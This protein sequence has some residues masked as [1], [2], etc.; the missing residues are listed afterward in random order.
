MGKINFSFFFQ[1]ESFFPWQMFGGCPV[2]APAYVYICQI[3]SDLAE[4]PAE[5]ILLKGRPTLRE[6]QK[7]NDFLRI[8][9]ER[10]QYCREIIDYQAKKSLSPGANRRQ[11]VFDFLANNNDFIDFFKK[12]IRY[13]YQQNY[14]TLPKEAFESE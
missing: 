3:M 14:I 2:S 13:K 11:E 6:L 8:N 10:S 7:Y 9:G 1:R 5:K 4:S 12:T